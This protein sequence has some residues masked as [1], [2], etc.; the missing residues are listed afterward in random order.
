[1]ITSRG[2]MNV[3]RHLLPGSTLSILHEQ[4]WH[5]L[6][7]SGI[8]I[9]ISAAL[10]LSHCADAVNRFAV[11]LLDHEF[12]ITGQL[13]ADIDVA[14]DVSG[15]GQRRLVVDALLLED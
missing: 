7:F 14:N 5:S 11:E 8:R 4:P 1:M 15:D 6:T 3:L 2:F 10:P 13:V 12:D 9:S